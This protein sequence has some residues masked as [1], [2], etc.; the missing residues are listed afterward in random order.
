MKNTKEASTAIMHGAGCHR[1]PKKG[2]L[3]WGKWRDD[4][5]EGVYVHH[6]VVVN[7]NTKKPSAYPTGS[8]PFTFAAAAP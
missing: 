7:E 6:L 2:D 8:H 3:R 4:G 5:G 1:P